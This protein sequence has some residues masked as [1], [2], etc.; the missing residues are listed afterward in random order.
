MAFLGD[1]KS[2][3][4]ELI[5]ALVSL[6]LLVDSIKKEKSQRETSDW[7]FRFILLKGIFFIIILLFYLLFDFQ[8]GYGTTERSEFILTEINGWYNSNDR[9]KIIL[10]LD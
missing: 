7:F 4:Y 2:L 6:W 9:W 8:R 3:V 5:L 10:F 1:D